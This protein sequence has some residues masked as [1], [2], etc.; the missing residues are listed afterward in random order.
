MYIEIKILSVSQLTQVVD[1]GYRDKYA[2]FLFIISILSII[3]E[4]IPKRNARC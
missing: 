4:T 1:N 2:L 3:S